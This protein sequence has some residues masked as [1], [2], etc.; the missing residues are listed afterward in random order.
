VK[1]GPGDGP[2]G[3]GSKNVIGINIQRKWNDSPSTV[4]YLYFTERF[5]NPL[6]WLRPLH[7]CPLGNKFLIDS[8]RLRWLMVRRP[9]AEL[10]PSR[11]FCHPRPFHISVVLFAR[12][13]FHVVEARLGVLQCI[14][15]NSPSV[16]S[17]NSPRNFITTILPYLIII[18]LLLNEQPRGGR[19]D[20]QRKAQKS[21][22]HPI[23]TQN[24]HSNII[25]GVQAA[26]RPIVTPGTN[27]PICV[28]SSIIST[29]P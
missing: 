26:S 22:H 1:V 27:S 4:N 28:S 9:M 6:M 17:T 23:I 8:C 29:R 2:W 12:G 15:P 21:Q 10:S 25:I 5:R 18:I 14:P 11:V 7:V 13:N 19:G 24:C 3:P 20:E 16:A